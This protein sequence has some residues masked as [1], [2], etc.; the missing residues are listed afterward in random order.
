ML[1][2]KYGKQINSE[3]YCEH[4]FSNILKLH[5]VHKTDNKLKHDTEGYQM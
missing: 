5:S 3:V 4:H 1:V 2:E